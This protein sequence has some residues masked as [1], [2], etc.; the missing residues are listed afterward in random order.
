M[1]RWLWVVSGELH[2]F[3]YQFNS[4][5]YAQYG[6]LSREGELVASVPVDIPA[7]V[8]MHDMGLAG[9]YVIMIDCCL[10]FKPEVCST[11]PQPLFPFFPFFT[12][13]TSTDRVFTFPPRPL[14]DKCNVDLTPFFSHPLSIGGRSGSH[15]QFWV[16]RELGAR[17]SVK[18]TIL[19]CKIQSFS[20]LK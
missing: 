8:M 12:N 2:F 16:L 4:R 6:R 14:R 18:I 15:P 7:P 17:L 1:A 3:G 20:A 19:I 10:A 9:D 11:G 5:P 13:S